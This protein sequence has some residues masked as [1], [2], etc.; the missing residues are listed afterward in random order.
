[1]TGA[2]ATRRLTEAVASLSRAGWLLTVGILV[3]SCTKESPLQY[4]VGESFETAADVFVR[5]LALE[6]PYL[7]V[8][9][10]DGVIKVER[11]SGRKVGHYTTQNGLMVNYAFT[12]SVDPRGTTWFGTNSGGLARVDGERVTTFHVRDGLA[13][14]WVYDIAYQRDGTMWAG[15][16]NGVSRYDGKA[17]TSYHV[18]DGL[19][20]R[21]VYAVAV[22]RDDSVW[23]GT[24]GGVSRFD[25]AT[26]TSW[27]HRDGLGAPN[28]AQLKS[29]DNTGLGA[30]TT[31]NIHRHDLTALDPEGRETYNENYVLSLLIDPRGVKWI[32]TWGGGV[33]RFDGRTWTNYT[34]QDG[35]AG[36]VVYAIAQDPTGRLWFGT[37]HGVC[38]YDGRTWATVSPA[39]RYA[40][41]DVYAV[42]VDT[43]RS[44]WIGYKGG[45]AHIT[46]R[47]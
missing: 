21:W 41:G 29:S 3:C 28:T 18:E 17:F 5:S 12:V 35:L 37:N 10:S 38:T 43:D 22:D 40:A 7:W 31:G 46:G 16:W 9:T 26:W 8:A 19:I 23:F 2:L 6:G 13:D 27:T 24:E 1:M 4:R 11:A 33:A 45:V 47:S 32:G 30:L 36:N 15:T 20:N 39:Q 44:V 25:G 34:T 42:V 14:P